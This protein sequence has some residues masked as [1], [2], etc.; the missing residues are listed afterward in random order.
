MVLQRGCQHTS[1]RPNL[2]SIISILTGVVL[3]VFS[4]VTYKLTGQLYRKKFTN[5]LSCTSIIF[6]VGMISALALCIFTGKNAALS[7]LFSAL[8]TG[9]MHGVNF[10]LV[11]MIPPFFKKTGNVSA[12]SGILNSCT[13]IGSAASTY[14][15][16][17]LSENFGWGFTLGA[18]LIVGIFGVLLCLISIKPFRK[19][20]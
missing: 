6:S 4:I 13:Y 3:P 8:L 15:V 5:P 11:G 9:A 1:V 16:A 12:V 17:L 19:Y 14:G 20:M 2:S 7:V 10:I 18:W